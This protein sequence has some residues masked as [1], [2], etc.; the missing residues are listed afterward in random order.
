MIAN[1]NFIMFLVLVIFS[2]ENFIEI[3]NTKKIIANSF[4]LR[5]IFKLKF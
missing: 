2:C 1:V 3:F 5:E 4:K